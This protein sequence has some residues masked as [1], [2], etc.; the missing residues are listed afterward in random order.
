MKRSSVSSKSRTASKGYVSGIA[1]EYLVLSM[2]YR[3]GLEAYM[4]LGS[5][6]NIDIRVV[7]RTGRALTVDV[8][9]VQ[10]YSSLVVNNVRSRRHHFVVFVIY[11][12]HFHDIGVNPDIFVVPSTLIPKLRSEYATQKRM[13]KGKIAP[14][15]NRWDFILGDSGP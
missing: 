2:L 15:R 4:T 1:S 6:K 7:A 9:S 5:K 10:G 11:N 8:K 3:L 12:N 14:F 13:M